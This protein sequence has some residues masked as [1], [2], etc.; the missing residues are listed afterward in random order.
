[1]PTIMPTVRF[2]NGHLLPQDQLRGLASIYTDNMAFLGTQSLLFTPLPVQGQ[3]MVAQA[4]DLEQDRFS[5]L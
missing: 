5:S 1:M 3:P 4:Q 2:L